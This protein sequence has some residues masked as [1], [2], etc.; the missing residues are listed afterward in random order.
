MKGA[1]YLNSRI[2]LLILFLF[3]FFRT[4]SLKAEINLSNLLEDVK[5]IKS[6]RDSSLAGE[7]F[8]VKKG[9]FLDNQNFSKAQSYNY[10]LF[11]RGLQRLFFANQEQSHNVKVLLY[12][13]S[14]VD[15]KQYKNS[16]SV[17]VND[18]DFWIK[19]VYQG[20]I[21][22]SFKQQ[23]YFECIRF[24][25]KSL[26]YTP[27]KYRYLY[28]VKSLLKTNQITL[29][30]KNILSNFEFY[31]SLFLSEGFSQAEQKRL[32]NI[33][34]SLVQYNKVS[35]PKN[36][37]KK[38]EKLQLSDEKMIQMLSS[39]YFDA[40]FHLKILN[41]LKKYL[42]LETEK[43][44]REMKKKEEIFLKFWKDQFTNLPPEVL[45]K[46]IIYAWR[47]NEI[48]IAINVSKIFLKKFPQHKKVPNI[49]YD[50]G[51]LYE[52]SLEY[53]KSLKIF[54]VAA[55]KTKGTKFY[56]LSLFRKS[57]LAYL[58]NSK[59]AISFFE[60]YLSFF[61]RGDF[62]QVSL[63]TILI[64]K[65]KSLKKDNSVARLKLENEVSQ[66][67]EKYPLSFYSLLLGD[68]WS[69]VFNTKM[70][71]FIRKKSKNFS[72]DSKIN[73]LYP[74]TIEDNEKHKLINEMYKIGLK[75]EAWHLSRHLSFNIDN[76]LSVKNHLNLYRKLDDTYS[77]TIK[78][79]QIYRTRKS[80]RDKIFID[81]IFPIFRE[82]LI[83]KVLSQNVSQNISPYFIMSVIRQESA[84]N[85]KAVSLAKARGLMQIIPSTAEGI[86]K[87]LSKP[88]FDM[89]NESDNL[90]FGIYYL[91]SLLKNFDNKIP[92]AL[93]AYN[94]GPEVTKRWILRRG[95]LSD[96]EFIES[97]PY[98][99]TRTYIKLILRNY[100]FYQMA[101]QNKN[102]HDLT[103]YS[104]KS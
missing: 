27:V 56:E 39:H 93:S 4:F 104:F 43:K 76:D 72:T 60:D 40:D 78:S 81:D 2:L 3:L 54:S 12:K 38:K 66:F 51:R 88:V 68:K 16:V 96:F 95:H 83:S 20:L 67:M 30:R 9:F 98:E 69:K 34:K 22:S 100:I 99:E 10:L 41:K 50:L 74:L 90:T 101:Y 18:V 19:K 25:E 71:K 53:E 33:L 35:R 79:L 31:S 42:D 46:F 32:K 59:D 73:D 65:E 102:F 37:D 63:Y 6:L 87:K 75:D 24:V 58:L 11:Y 84:F 94:A 80:F 85:P 52:D 5:T 7:S 8:T 21:E 70:K 61:P 36:I 57:W 49:L 13:K 23:Q 44:E 97:I 45:D 103:L 64:L 62:S 14:Y 47:K 29:L 86:G 92:Y 26:Q 1:F 89:F 28:Y 91:K 15:F 17:D 48:P 55:E 77:L 82:N